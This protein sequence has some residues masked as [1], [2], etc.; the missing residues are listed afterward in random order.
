VAID[1]R[2]LDKRFDRAQSPFVFDSAGN[3]LWPDAELIK[4][5]SSK[6]VN[7]GSLQSY[8]TSEAQLGGFSN[9]TRVKATKVQATRFAP[10][11]NYI[12]DAV[13][14]SAAAARFRSAG[15]ACRVVFLKD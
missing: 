10:S 3:Q 2:G 13:L 11:S 12:T 1:V 8:A 7:E 9:L 4:G 15:S 6:L 5:V 14:D